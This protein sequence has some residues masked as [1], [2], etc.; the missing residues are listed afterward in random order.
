M[1][2]TVVRYLGRTRSSPKT[3]KSASFIADLILRKI[4]E[5]QNAANP[6][7]SSLPSP[8]LLALPGGRPPILVLIACS[9]TKNTGGELGYQGGSPASW[10]AEPYLK[11]RIVSKRSNVYGL[12]KDAKIVDAFEEGRNRIYSQANKSLSHGPDLGGIESIGQKCHYL[13]AWKRYSGQIYTPIEEASWFQHFS[14]PRALTVLIMSGLYGLIDAEEKIQDYDIHLS[15]SDRDTGQ[16][17]KTMWSDLYTETIKHYLTRAFSGEKV[18]IFN[19]L[20]DANYVTAIEWLELPKEKCSVYHLASPELSDV[21]LLPA[22]GT[23]LN[24]FLNEPTKANNIQKG[25]PLNL[26]DFGRRRRQC[27]I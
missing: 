4:R 18:K 17:V 27:R 15:D 26:S 16:R 5:V 1:I 10:I 22:A 11:D 25:L 23:I 9:R 20:C 21:H 19:L 2:G 6:T 8:A 12:L 13:P 24:R 14:G 3:L 7:L